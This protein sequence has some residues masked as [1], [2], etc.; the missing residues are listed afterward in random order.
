M[1]KN[2]LSW[3]LTNDIDIT[4]WYIIFLRYM[5][6]TIYDYLFANNSTVLKKHIPWKS[7]RICLLW[8]RWLSLRHG[9]ASGIAQHPNHGSSGPIPISKTHP[10]Y[11][12]PAQM[13]VEVICCYSH[14]IEIKKTIPRG[15]IMLLKWR[16]S[17]RTDG[18]RGSCEG[19]RQMERP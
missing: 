17:H 1:K 18:L 12:G 7:Y 4:D 6:G 2:V 13:F 3:H 5:P 19:L 9:S 8:T 14:C 10:F 11:K 16:F 15:C